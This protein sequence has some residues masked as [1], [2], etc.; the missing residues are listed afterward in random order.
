MPG[1]HNK[2]RTNKRLPVLP[3]RQRIFPWAFVFGLTA[4]GLF[5]TAIVLFLSARTVAEN[6]SRF[7][8]APA[9]IS[10][11]NINCRQEEWV[12]I[13]EVQSSGGKNPRSVLTVRSRNGQ[14]VKLVDQEHSGLTY[15]LGPEMEALAVFWEDEIVELISPGGK[16]MVTQNNPQWKSKDETLAAVL[17]A[18]AAPVFL[19][20]AVLAA[21]P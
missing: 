12:R 7:R 10:G 16:R 8:V 13:V 5:L 4:M 15:D 18:I 20:F 1:H 6:A 2:E 14:E 19:G 3:L 11:I 17:S 21:R 9:C